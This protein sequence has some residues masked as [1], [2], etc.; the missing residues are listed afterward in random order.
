MRFFLFIL[1]VFLFVFGQQKT[2]VYIDGGAAIVEDK[3]VLKSDLNQMS[4]MVAIQKGINPKLNYES[5][6]KLQSS[7]L[8]TMIDQKI[9]LKLAEEDTT[10]EVKDKDV[11]TALEQQL[12]NLVLQAGGKKEAEKMLGQSLKSFE[13]EFWFEMKDKMVSEMYQQKVLSNI[14]TNK[15]D[16]VSFYAVYKDSLPFFPLEI[17]LRHILIKPQPSDSVKKEILVFLKK[18]KNKIESKENSFSYYAKKHS[19]DPGSKNRGGELGWYG[20]GELVKNF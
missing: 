7:V 4:N 11:N 17:K 18:I 1:V 19:M 2:P 9:L 16:V 20:R 6:L 3:I 8:E 14:K 5:F 15:S 12:D 10:I 13:S